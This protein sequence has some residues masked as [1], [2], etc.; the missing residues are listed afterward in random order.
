MED[1]V[2]MTGVT[3]VNPRTYKQSPPHRGRGGLVDSAPP[4][5]FVLLRQSGKKFTMSR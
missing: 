2:T 1:H 4:L 5:G 3:G